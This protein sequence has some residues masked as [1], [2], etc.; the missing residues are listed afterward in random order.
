MPSEGGQFPGGGLQEREREEATVLTVA[1]VGLASC[2]VPQIPVQGQR[3]SDL[4]LVE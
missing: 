2:T 3:L 1:G 4:L